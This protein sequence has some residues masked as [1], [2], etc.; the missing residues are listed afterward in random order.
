MTT[1]DFLEHVTRV[2][3]RFAAAL[4]GKIATSFADLQA[5]ADGG[6]DAVELVIT[7]HRRLHE[8]CGLAPTLDFPRTGSAAGLARTAIREAAKAKRPAT[9]EEAAALRSA[10]EVLRTDAA[11]EL[12]AYSEGG[13]ADAS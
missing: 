11:A 1:D 6:G 2:R 9:P 10:L 3:A 4:A 12:Q 5:I 8:I 7:V 13:K